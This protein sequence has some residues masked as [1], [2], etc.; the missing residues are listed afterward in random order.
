MQIFCNE[1]CHRGAL[2]FEHYESSYMIL[3]VLYQT[4]QLLLQSFIGMALRSDRPT[5][6]WQYDPLIA[7]I[8]LCCEN[9]LK[10]CMN[11]IIGNKLFVIMWL[12]LLHLTRQ[13]KRLWKPIDIEVT[14]CQLYGWMVF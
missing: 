13:A 6:V 14:A 12:S 5:F 4:T 11:D 9:I 3:Q 8:S 10:N 1:Y 7:V 2:K